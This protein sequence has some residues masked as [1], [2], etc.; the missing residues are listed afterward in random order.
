MGP[1]L[2]LKERIDVLEKLAESLKEYANWWRNMEFAHRTLKAR[3]E[4]NILFSDMRYNSILQTWIDFRRDYEAYMLQVRGNSILFILM[5]LLR[6][7]FRSR[8]YRTSIQTC[9]GSDGNLLG[10]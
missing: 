7:M 8:L 9:S 1:A 10:R 6:W 5:H 3:S 2:T 4:A